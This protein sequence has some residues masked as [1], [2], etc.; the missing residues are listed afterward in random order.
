MVCHLGN[1]RPECY[2]VNVHVQV[3]HVSRESFLYLS[4]F[5]IGEIVPEDRP[6]V[7]MPEVLLILAHD[8]P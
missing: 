6:V 5:Y 2:W 4:E 1:L 8:K 3:Y 7:P